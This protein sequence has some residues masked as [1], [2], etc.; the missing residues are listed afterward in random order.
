VQRI[1][2]WMMDWGRG[3]RERHNSKAGRH[4]NWGKQ[5]RAEDTPT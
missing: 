2:Y 4:N 1:N 3:R 5:E